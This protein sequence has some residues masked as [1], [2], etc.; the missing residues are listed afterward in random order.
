[1][2][3]DDYDDKEWCAIGA[4]ILITSILYGICIV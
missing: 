3:E 4:L 2:N 1:M